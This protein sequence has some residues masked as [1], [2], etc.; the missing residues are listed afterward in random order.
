MRGFIARRDLIVAAAA[1]GLVAFYTAAAGGGFPLDDSWI[2][3]VYGRSFGTLGEW[4]F[5][6]GQPSA[7]STS[8]LYTVLLAIGYRLGLPYGWYTH[9]LGALALAGCGL[10]AGRLA[11]YA[12]PH[13]PGRALFVALMVVLT[14]HHLW[15]AAAGMELIVLMMLT[16][17]LFLRVA[18]EAQ[19]ERFSARRAGIFGVSVG[20]A[21]LTRPEGMLLGALCGAALLLIR[22]RGWLDIVRF[23]VIALLACGVVMAPYLAY[24]VQ[25]TGGLLPDTGEAKFR[26]AR[27]LYEQPLTTR[28]SRAL[29]ALLAGGQAV[30]LLGIVPFVA[31]ALADRRRVVLL[32]PLVS[33]AAHILLY[34]AQLPETYQH[35]RY[36]MP[37]LSGLVFCG[38]YGAAQWLAW[39]R[40]KLAHRVASRVLVGVGVAT[41]LAYALV[42][43]LR[44]YTNDVAV[45]DTEMVRSAL[46]IRDNVPQD[47]L[48]AVHDI[49][50]VGYFSQRPA[51]LDVAGLITP[52]IVPLLGQPEAMWQFLQARGAGYIVGFPPQIP[53]GR[54]DDP[55]LCLVY[56]TGSQPAVAQGY[57][58]MS[59]YRIA[60]DHNCP[61][62]GA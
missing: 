19:A 31:F 21:A 23:G 11:L 54:T 27:L 51:L 26:A 52:E 14:W 49:G 13:H 33:S 17:W 18:A 4:S 25:L 42:L 16:L 12:G 55:R 48:L 44:A 29:S 41:T 39:G 45:I 6:P 28:I 7:A 46:W 30:W 47:T 50:A 35:G 24:N 32:L 62:Q 57:A 34:A 37:A 2:H 61:A 60:W 36:F 22:P 43:G 1:L 8:P 5:I 40:D 53:G 38:A 10:L 3:Q 20:L 59:V 15:A 9:M 58:N 56:T